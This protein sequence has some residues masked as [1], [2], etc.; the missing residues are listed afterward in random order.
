LE[1]CV[2]IMND[3]LF[4]LSSYLQNSQPNRI[5]A[6]ILATNPFFT[7]CLPHIFGPLATVRSHISQGSRQRTQQRS[8][9]TVVIT[10]NHFDQ[11]ML[12]FDLKALGAGRSGAT[13]MVS[14]PGSRGDSDE[15]DWIR[16]SSTV[17]FAK[18]ER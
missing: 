14:R 17:G 6:S 13:S 4:L 7:S 10:T 2:L 5:C 12:T 15:D 8:T 16:I 18:E 11:E 3:R 9:H 1:W